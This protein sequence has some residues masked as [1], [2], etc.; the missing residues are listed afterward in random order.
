MI[1]RKFFRKLEKKKSE[2]NFLPTIEMTTYL[3]LILATPAHSVQTYPSHSADYW[4][5]FCRPFGVAAVVV[6]FFDS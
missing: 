6:D 3:C 4:H 1:D 2:E 5:S